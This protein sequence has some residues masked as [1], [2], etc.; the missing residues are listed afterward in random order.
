M[1]K[2][3]AVCAKTIRGSNKRLLPQ[4]AYEGMRRCSEIGAFRF[5]NFQTLPNVKHAI[6]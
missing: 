5:Y 6:L 1:H 2:F 3:Q 4:L